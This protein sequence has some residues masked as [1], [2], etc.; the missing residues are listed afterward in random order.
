VAIAEAR[1]RERFGVTVITVNSPE[2]DI[3]VN[4]PAGTTIKSGQA[5]CMWFA[6]RIVVNFNRAWDRNSPKQPCCTH[7]LKS[8][9]RAV[10]HIATTGGMFQLA[11]HRNCIHLYSHNEP[12]EPGR[13]HDQRIGVRNVLLERKRS[14]PRSVESPFSC[15]ART[16]EIHAAFQSRE[17]AC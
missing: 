8:S 7:Q 4:P 15:P 13:W 9:C 17:S 3:L 5:P 1:V 10:S 2:G 12:R 11:F 6:K 16:V 14:L